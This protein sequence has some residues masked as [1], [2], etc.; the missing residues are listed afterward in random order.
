MRS[1]PL[2]TALIFVALVL[3]VMPAPVLVDARILAAQAQ[4][5]AVLSTLVAE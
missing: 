4:R 2:Y 5:H 1:H 3:Y